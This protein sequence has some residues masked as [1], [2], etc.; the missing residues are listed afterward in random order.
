MIELLAVYVKNKSHFPEWPSMM[1]VMEGIVRM[2]S[3]N[4]GENCQD[5]VKELRNNNARKY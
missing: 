1:I 4:S 5:E 3:Y 2:W